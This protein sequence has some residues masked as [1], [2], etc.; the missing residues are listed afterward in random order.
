MLGVETSS[1]WSGAVTLV[2]SAQAMIQAR[3]TASAIRDIETPV[4]QV[5]EGPPDAAVGHHVEQTLAKS[6]VGGIVCCAVQIAGNG[7]P[8]DAIS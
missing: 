7:C 1:G 3:K 2:W 5:N 4:A 6:V 8:L